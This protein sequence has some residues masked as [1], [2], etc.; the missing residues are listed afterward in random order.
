MQDPKVA[1]YILKL[2]LRIF[3]ILSILIKII[4][5]YMF[6][7]LKPMFPPSSALKLLY[8]IFKDNQEL[9]QE[10]KERAL[11]AKHY[12]FNNYYKVYDNYRL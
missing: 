12:A 8:E 4:V 7:D 3:Q 10:L 1:E 9:S 2:F 11:K 6:L 5:N